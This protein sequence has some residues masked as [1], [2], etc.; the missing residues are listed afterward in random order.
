M[1]RSLDLSLLHSANL[2]V[3]RSVLLDALLAF[4]LT[5]YFFKFVPLFAIVIRLW[6]DDRD[7]SA[8][9]KILAGLVGAFAA[10]VAGRLLQHFLPLR[11]RPQNALGDLRLPHGIEPEIM[12]DW[13]SFPSDHAML[14]FAAG[15]LIWSVSRRWGLVAFLWSAVLVCLPRVALGMH[16]PSD[17]IGGALLGMAI[18]YPA[19]RLLPPRLTPLLRLV[20]DLPQYA[21]PAAFLGAFLL[22][23]MFDDPRRL[24]QIL[25]HGNSEI[26]VATVAAS[27]TG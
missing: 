27:S 13:T 10:L 26:G 11:P 5:A 15:L 23:T 25:K 3:G 18:T 4:I 1:L 20:T 19:L 17:V 6:F 16:Y 2:L 12:R 14:A 24:E 9:L 21:A 7:A 8:R 22:A